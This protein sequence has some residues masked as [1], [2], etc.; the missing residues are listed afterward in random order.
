MLYVYKEDVCFRNY[1]YFPY[2]GVCTFSGGLP[3]NRHGGETWAPGLRHAQVP[4]RGIFRGKRGSKGDSS[5][6]GNMAAQ[7][8]G[9]LLCSIECTHY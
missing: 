2:F 7:A 8:A 4:C 9:V 6:G 5:F 3:F 1:S